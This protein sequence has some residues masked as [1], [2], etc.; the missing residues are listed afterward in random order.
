MSLN[1][2][3]SS[4]QSVSLGIIVARNYRGNVERTNYERQESPWSVRENTDYMW[5]AEGD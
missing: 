3:Q 1:K 2:L 5:G 4:V